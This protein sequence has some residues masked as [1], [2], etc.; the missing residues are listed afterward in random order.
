[1]EK[2]CVKPVPLGAPVPPKNPSPQALIDPSAFNPAKAEPVEK[3]CVK[4]VPVGAPV[5][6]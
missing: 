2:T 4:P 1:M 3:T 6:P 5:P